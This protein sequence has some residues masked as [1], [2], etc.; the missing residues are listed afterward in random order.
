MDYIISNQ[1]KTIQDILFWTV[2]FFSKADIYYGHGTNNAWDEAIRLVLPTIY[3]PLNLPKNLYLMKLTHMERERI[4]NRVIR[5]VKERI[6]IAYL[7]NKAWFCNYEF[8]IDERVLI[9]RSPLSEL[10][11]KRFAS[12]LTKEPKYILD[13]CTGSG[14]IAIACSYF[15]PNAIIHATDISIDALTV[16][17]HNIT[18]HKMKSFVTPVYSDLF[19]EIKKKYDIIISNPPY[20]GE[21]KIKCLPPEY[22]FEPR[23]G[24][25]ARM[26]GLEIIHRIL[27]QASD[28]LT[29]NGMLICEVG[30][31]QEYLIEKYPDVPFIWLEF[32]RGGYGVFMLTKKQLIA[33]QKSLNQLSIK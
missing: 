19:N 11:E 20:V 15:F 32:E 12:L 31:H 1:L 5:R 29:D 9:P 3:L 21:N 17:E 7:T 14:C 8:Y 27:L 16:T 24:L 26:E 22:H 33:S 18:F 10:I 6:P 13:L 30:Y 23:I 2:S 4:I 28:Y 25:I